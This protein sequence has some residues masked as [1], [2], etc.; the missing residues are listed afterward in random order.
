[1]L[2]QKNGGALTEELRAQLEKEEVADGNLELE[3]GR[4]QLLELDNEW[5]AL[6]DPLSLTAISILTLT[7]TLT[8]VQYI[9]DK[10]TPRLKERLGNFWLQGEPPAAFDLGHAPLIVPQ[11]VRPSDRP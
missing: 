2:G 7:E 11:R 5:A 8:V 4:L 10:L 3:A 1:M 9:N 6:I